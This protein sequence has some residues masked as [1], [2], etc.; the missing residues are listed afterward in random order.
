MRELV[1]FR[2]DHVPIDGIAT[3]VKEVLELFGADIT[4][5]T[6]SEV[7]F[8]LPVS[9]GVAAAGGIA[10][11]II[12]R[13]EST[14]EGS[15]VLSAGKEIAAPKMQQIALLGVGA[16]GAVL[17]L[18][19]P[20]FPQ[21]ASVSGVGVIVAFATYFMMMKRTPGGVAADILRRI[22]ARQCDDEPRSADG[23]GPEVANHPQKQD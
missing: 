22:V 6:D 17:A 18:M 16:I 11:S 19:W 7:R 10:C 23:D 8:E 2:E 3:S 21:M 14:G 12:W 9:R 20:F 4:S 1:E 13:E 15:L 5:S